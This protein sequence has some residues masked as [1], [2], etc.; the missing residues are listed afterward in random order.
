MSRQTT[1]KAFEIF[2]VGIWPCS[3]CFSAGYTYDQLLTH[4]KS[5][6]K[7]EPFAVALDGEAEVFKNSYYCAISRKVERGG[8]EE[9]L[10][11]ISLHNP[12]DFTNHYNFCQLAHEVLHICQFMLPY[13]L[14]MEKEI[15]AVAYTH[16]FIMDKCLSVM[17]QARAKSSVL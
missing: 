16:T 12:F 11:F 1:K 8:H 9:N 5:D 10:Y 14:D 13:F 2:D 6:E 17:K 7:L 3:I 15:E 4:L